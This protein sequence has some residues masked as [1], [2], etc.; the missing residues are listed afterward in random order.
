MQDI[1]LFDPHSTV[2][3]NKALRALIE[4]PQGAYQK[5]RRREAPFYEM[6]RA[7]VLTLGGEQPGDP[8]PPAG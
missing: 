8:R 5:W 2:C 6:C 1:S 7:V 4:D 3:T